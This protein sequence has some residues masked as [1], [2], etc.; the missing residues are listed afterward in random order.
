MKLHSAPLNVLLATH[1][2]LAARIMLTDMYMLTLGLPTDNPP[3]IEQMK[4]FL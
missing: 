1:W 2:L 3:T 4:D